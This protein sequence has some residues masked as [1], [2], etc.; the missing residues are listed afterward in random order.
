MQLRL[1]RHPVSPLE[2]SA[3]A[4]PA[5]RAATLRRMIDEL[6]ETVESRW[7]DAKWACTQLALA[8]NEARADVHPCCDQPPSAHTAAADADEPELRRIVDELTH[9]ADA[10]GREAQWARAEL[11]AAV[12]PEPRLGR[13]IRYG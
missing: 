1:R 6:N 3:D 5:T 7:W 13:G 2:P 12:V 10:L 11:A 4:D 9:T 8:R